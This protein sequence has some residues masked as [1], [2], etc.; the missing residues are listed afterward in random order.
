V[1]S[2]QLQQRAERVHG[3]EFGGLQQGVR[4]SSNSLS[5]PQQTDRARSRGRSRSAG[6]RRSSPPGDGFKRPAPEVVLFPF[7]DPL[8]R[9]GPMVAEGRN[10]SSSRRAQS[11]R[12][13]AA[14]GG[15]GVADR[16]ATAQPRA[17]SRQAAIAGLLQRAE[18]PC[19]RSPVFFFHLQAQVSSSFLG[20]GGPDRR[21]DVRPTLLGG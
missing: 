15:A 12:I 4:R 2:T 16:A 19:Q 1:V 17:R 5:A 10:R 6:H 8:P 13:G 3:L 21:R 14:G 18:R 11:R 20:E 7:A 9:A